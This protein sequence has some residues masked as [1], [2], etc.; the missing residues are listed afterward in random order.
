MRNEAGDIVQDNPEE[1]PEWK[2]K[3]RVA[4]TAAWDATIA[5][6]HEIQDKTIACSQATNKA[7]RENPYMALGAA[8]GAGFLFG[9]L[10][11]GRG[12]TR[13]EEEER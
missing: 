11:F 6:Y 10:L 1:T 5:A 4:G 7:I 2:A 3:A 9:L 12:G 13:E 8:I